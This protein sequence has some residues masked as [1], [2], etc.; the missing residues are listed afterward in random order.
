[1]LW[2][3]LALLA[4]TAIVAWVLIFQLLRQHG[5]LLLRF[6]RLEE[7]LA[8]SG[9]EGFQVEEGPQGIPAGSPIPS[10][11]LPDVR[12]G[13]ASLE[14]YRGKRVLLVNW[15]PSCGFCD[16]I[17]PDLAKATGKLR[18]RNTELVLVT[19]GDAE[20]N[21]ALAHEHG[22]DCPMLLTDG[23][24]GLEAFSGAGTP[25]AYLLDEEGRVE[26]GLVF[27]ADKVPELL[28][29][30]LDG[31]VRLST[32]KSLSESRLEREGLKVGTPAP[33][34]SLPGVQGETVTLGDH[35]GQ[36]VLVIF[37]DPHCGPCNELTPDLARL[38]DD[39]RRAGLQMVMVT[40]GE[41]EENRDK[42]DEHALEFPIAIQRGWRLSKEYGIFATPVA[43]LVDE[44]GVI[45]RDVAKGP[46]EIVA[47]IESEL[48]VR[49]EAP[50]EA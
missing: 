9:L 3:L 26:R 37:S 19:Y 14:D 2:V 21:L 43:F 11:R 48:S 7:R 12:G 4:F 24:H 1:V 40:R 10:F 18:K 32:E 23:S 38:Q 44:R 30:A 50:M 5:Q 35:R 27:G 17:A 45:A 47:V 15:G 36:R 29:D 8:A 22:F 34:F 42:R 6:D 46:D 39:A 13:T 25:A 33:D 28:Q 20:A 49:E 31:R 41:L 16:A